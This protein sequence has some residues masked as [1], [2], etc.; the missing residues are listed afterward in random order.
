MR[1]G[2]NRFF[3]NVAYSDAGF[4]F[5]LVRVEHFEKLHKCF[6]GVF[7]AARGNFSVNVVENW[8]IL[9]AFFFEFRCAFYLI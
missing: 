7:A 8:H 6:V 1:V 9:V 4:F 2:G 5:Y 3:G